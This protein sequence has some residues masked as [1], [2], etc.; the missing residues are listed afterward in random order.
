MTVEPVINIQNL[1]KSF[2]GYAV[3]RGVD[4]AMNEGEIC[5]ILGHSGCGK[6]VLLKCILGLIAPDQGNISFMNHDLVD[7]L[8]DRELKRQIGMVFQSGALFDFLSVF[9]NV[10][11]PLRAFSPLNESG[12][13]DQVNSMLEE[14]SLQEVTDFFPSR[15]SGGMKRRVALARTLITSPKLILYDEPTVGLDPE[16]VSGINELITGQAKSRRVSSLVVTHDL[17]SAHKIADRVGL[18][19][20]GKIVHLQNKTAFF[21]SDEPEVREFLHGFKPH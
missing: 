2:N 10:A 12:I 3:L 14:L 1:H 8:N 5:V 20:A 4:F 9:E 21:A 18:H 17:F 16:R 11:L 19:R 7:Y 6:S 15:L 13:S